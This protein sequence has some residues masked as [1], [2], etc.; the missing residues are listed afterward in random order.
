MKAIQ[1]KYLGCTN[2]RP[3]RWKAFVEGG[4]FC[5][6]SYDHALNPEEN[7]RTAAI[8]LMRKLGW[9]YQLSEPGGLPNGDYVFTLS[10]PQRAH[11]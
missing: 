2:H 5:V 1:V 3:S 11:A 8:A 7:A 4:A 10:F 9:D 6:R